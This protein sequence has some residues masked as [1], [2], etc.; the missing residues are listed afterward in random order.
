[1]PTVEPEFVPGRL[2]FMEDEPHKAMILAGVMV[3]YALEYVYVRCGVLLGI[4]GLGPRGADQSWQRYR[5]LRT[6]IRQLSDTPVSRGEMP[7]PILQGLSVQ[8]FLLCNISHSTSGI[9]ISD[10]GVETGLV[11]PVVR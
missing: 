9:S 3:H 7:M 4:I 2:K 5:L 10:Q 6:H 1:M 11:C 8:L